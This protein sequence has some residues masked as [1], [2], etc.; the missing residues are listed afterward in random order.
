MITNEECLQNFIDE[1]SFRLNQRTLYAYRKDVR[2]LFAH[3]HKSFGL[4]TSRDIRS[5]M[6]DLESRY[7]PNSIRNMLIGVKLFYKYCLEEEIITHSP[8]A[9]VPYPELDEP[10]THYLENDQLAELRKLVTGQLQERAVIEVL[11]T[12][13][14]RIG[15]MASLKKE[16]IDWSE[17]IMHIRKGK[18]KKGRIVLFT[19]SCAELLQVYLQDR[20]DDQ[21]FLFV[22]TTGTGPICVRTVQYN[23][24]N[25]E[26]KLGIHLSP[27]TLRHTFAAHLAMKG[28]P[29]AG[30]QSLLGHVTPEQTQLY[31]KL[32]NHERK[33][34]YDEWM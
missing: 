25:Y 2:K 8:V 13:G 18:H 21:P 5:W 14:V 20:Q 33:Q 9:F 34:M 23:F 15:E 29:L 10:I 1:Y 30:I 32:F 7:K 26:K 24:D 3:C 17:R 31:A 27:H 4:I 12:T 19:R 16:D 28:M 6:Q 11:Y 22:N